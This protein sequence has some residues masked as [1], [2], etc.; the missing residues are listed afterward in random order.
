MSADD[1]VQRHHTFH[2]PPMKAGETVEFPLS[3]RAG[4]GGQLGGN[5]G[6]FGDSTTPTTFQ[7]VEID[8]RTHDNSA[9]VLTSVFTVDG[10]GNKKAFVPK[11]HNQTHT[12]VGGEDGETITYVGHHCSD[13]PKTILYNE[14]S[15]NLL[16]D[17]KINQAVSSI[18][19]SKAGLSLYDVADEPLG[20]MHKNKEGDKTF[21]DP[22]TLVGRVLQH[23]NKLGDSAA[24]ELDGETMTMNTVK[25]ADFEDVKK[26]MSALKDIVDTHGVH[27]VSFRVTAMKDHNGACVMA[28][29]QPHPEKG[30]KYMV[31]PELLPSSPATATLSS[32]FSGEPISV[33]PVIPCSGSDVAAPAA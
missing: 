1:I 12:I 32:S 14:N 9:A 10:N 13:T 21:V 27:D 4:C 33:K 7:S 25:E 30:G 8:A 18:K 26:H 2:I 5:P 22:T 19:Y 3:H 31:N 6:K 29:F 24:V 11:G 20:T 16:K 23:N 15:M 28:K 17:P